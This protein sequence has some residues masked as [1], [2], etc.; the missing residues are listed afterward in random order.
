MA[1]DYS[2]WVYIVIKRNSERC[3][4]SSRHDRATQHRNISHLVANEVEAFAGERGGSLAVPK[5]RQ[6]LQVSGQAFHQRPHSAHFARSE[7]ARSTP[8]YRSG[9][10]LQDAGRHG[11]LTCSPEIRGRGT[12][13]PP[14]LEA[15]AYSRGPQNQTS[16]PP[17][18]G[19][20]VANL[21]HQPS[22][23]IHLVTD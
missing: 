1:R 16:N 11:E 5:K 6:L 18:D 20:A 9:Q 22:N 21:K 8:D 7:Q 23:F 15:R 4:H 10:A 3:L 17:A 12:E 19:F 14:T 13:A 2:F